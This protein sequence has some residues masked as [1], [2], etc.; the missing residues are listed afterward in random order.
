MY[1]AKNIWQFARVLDA[2]EARWEVRPVFHRLE[3]RLRE[4]V[5]VA[6]WGLLWLLAMCGSTSSAATN[7]ERMLT[8][9]SAC[10]VSI[11]GSMA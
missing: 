3:L 5:V 10:R 8:P 6:T 9:R 1:Q 11:P 4:V 7:L 2:A